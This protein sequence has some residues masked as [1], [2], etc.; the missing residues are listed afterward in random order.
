M[1]YQRF[2]P[3]CD[4]PFEQGDAVL[5][6]EGCDVLHHPACWVRNEGCVTAEEHRQAPIAEAYL[7]GRPAPQ[8]PHPGEGTRVRI[9]ARERPEGPPP[10]RFSGQ[11]EAPPHRGSPEI[12]SDD[13]DDQVIGAPLDP[14]EPDPLVASRER[15]RRGAPG[16]QAPYR[17]TPPR[18][19][20][21]RPEPA[22]GRRPL[23]QVY[24]RPRLLDY[25][26]VPIAVAIAIVVA[27]G[28]I[29]VSDRI[30]GSSGDDTPAVADVPRPSGGGAADTPAADDTPTP[31]PVPAGT[32][33]PGDIV[34]VTG[35][36]ECLN[37]R[38]SPGLDN[39]PVACLPDGSEFEI[40][41][42]PELIGDL[43]WWQVRTEQGDGWA[44]EDYLRRR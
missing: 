10:Q 30:F 24:S 2:C 17:P 18:R 20:Q 40:L 34:V 1:S 9:P 35:S 43:T 19:Y 38:P 32:F 36:G 37:V 31:T 29:W 11:R 39:T 3:V 44:A 5:R 23:P 15:R 42:G 12:G 21:D 16:E 4:R 8:T 13:F 25:W 41:A 28:V 33:A 6:C 27:F 7:G 14:G 22:A 26:Y